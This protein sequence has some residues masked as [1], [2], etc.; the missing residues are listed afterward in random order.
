MI[1][2][3]VDTGLC[4]QC[5]TCVG[6]CPTRALEYPD[7]PR[8][9][10]YPRLVEELCTWCDLCVETCS[11]VSYDFGKT[12]ARIAPPEARSD[13]RLGRVVA[14]YSGFATDA[15]E[16]HAGASGGLTTAILV[17]ALRSGRIDGAVVAEAEPGS[18]S[19]RV[20]IARTEAEIRRAAASK[21]IPVPTG[22]SLIEIIRTPGR[23]AVVG[24]PCH[25]HGYRKVEERLE[26]RVNARIV[27]YLALFCSH[28][29]D[30]GY[31]R[32][33]LHEAGVAERDVDTLGFRGRGWPGEFAVRTKSGEERTI[34]Y[35]GDF[36][37]AL[38]KT[39][40]FTPMRCL[41]CPD[42]IGE[43]ADLSLGDA[44]LPRFGGDPVGTSLVVSHTTRGEEILREAAAAGAIRLDPIAD[45][46]VVESQKKVLHFKKVR[47]HARRRILRALGFAVPHHGDGAATVTAKPT[48][49]D[50]VHSAGTLAIAG[51]TASRSFAP[52]F[53]RFPWH[54]ALRARDLVLRL[55]GRKAR[56]TIE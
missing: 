16:R 33:L 1:E 25:V 34:P 22:A 12:E 42:V 50:Y 55:L 54:R 17:H 38:W 18:V 13:S 44:W 53:E 27:L 49:F 28:T 7:D 52:L 48:A 31:V 8:E 10:R 40:A 39:Y 3:V 23:Y 41:T 30:A 36:T 19:P 24:L 56:R 26:R 2:H 9:N 46:E 32:S 15:G 37:Q 21:Y 51:L 47:I 5:G 29:K 14:S 35:G 45:E 43:T 20:F 11:G 4:T 6:V